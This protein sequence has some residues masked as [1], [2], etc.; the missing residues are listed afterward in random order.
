MLMIWPWL[1]CYFPLLMKFVQAG[2]LKFFGTRNSPKLGSLLYSLYKIPL[3][4]ACFPLAWPNFHS[5]WRAGERYF[6]SL[7]VMTSTSCRHWLILKSSGYNDWIWVNKLYS[8]DNETK[9]IF[10]L[11][12]PRSNNRKW[13]F[14]AGID[15]TKIERLTQFNFLGLRINLWIGAPWKFLIKFCALCL[16]VYYF[17]YRKSSCITYWFISYFIPNNV[18]DLSG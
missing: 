2:K 7:F 17:L 10:T 18:W 15:N 4:Q 6:P 5:H 12:L 13:N 11:Q 1:V 3:A 9:F 8:N 16:D 14:T